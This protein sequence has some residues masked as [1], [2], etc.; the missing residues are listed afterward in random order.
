MFYR[1]FNMNKN[2]NIGYRLNYT[3]HSTF[4]AFS[5]NSLSVADC[6]RCEKNIYISAKASVNKQGG[7]KDLGISD[8]THLI[9]IVSCILTWIISYYRLIV[10]SVLN[11]DAHKNFQVSKSDSFKDNGMTQSFILAVPATPFTWK[12]NFI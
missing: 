3:E 2:L 7:F 1:Q 9:I 12:L 5:F 8:H 11:G 10:K 6:L 4:F